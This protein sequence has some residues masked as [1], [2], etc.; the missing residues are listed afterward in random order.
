MPSRLAL[1][2]TEVERV[3]EV[4]VP[5]DAENLSRF[6]VGKVLEC[7]RHPDADKLSVCTV[8]VGEGTARTIVCGAPNVAAG[9]TVAVVLPGGVMPDGTRIKDAKLRGVASAGMILSEAELG[10]AAKSPGTMVLPD[11]WKAG[12]LLI[13]HFAHLR[14]G[15]RGRGHAQP[16]RLPVDQGPGARDRRHHRDAVRGG[17]EVSAPLGRAAGRRG[18]RHRGARPGS[19]PP[20][21]RRVIRGVTIGRIAAVDEGPHQP[22]GHAPH[23]Q[24]GGRDELRA[25]GARPAAARVRSSHHPGRPHHRAPGSPRRG[26]DHARQRAR[27]C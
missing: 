1:T 9:Q 8:D 4:G 18:H 15:A 20:V 10:L 26:T 3:T 16:A 5:G 2:G 11:G 19:L 25:V 24:R 6:V 23:Q 13:D 17:H 27:E 21:R 14:L 12:E 7:G 22:R